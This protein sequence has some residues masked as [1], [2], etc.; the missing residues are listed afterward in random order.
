MIHIRDLTVTYGKIPAL[1]NITFDV[2]PGSWALVSGASGCGKSTL[3]RLLGGLIPHAIPAKISGEISIA[4]F[5]PRQSTIPDLAQHV[6]LVFQNPSTQ[7]FHLR[8]E[9]EVAF[10]PRNL[11]LSVDEVQQ[12]VEWAIQAANLQELRLRR[13]SEL[14]GGQKQ[15]VVIAGALAMQ[16]KVLV[17]DEPTA[18]L[19][20]ANTRRVLE[21]L[22]TLRREQGITILMIEHRLA[23]TLQM[24]DQIILLEKGRLLV[25]GKPSE[26][27]SDPTLLRR[28][29]LRRPQM[30]PFSPGPA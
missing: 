15:C 17:L 20:V 10:G 8:V 9:D 24:A 14:S 1:E 30:N 2:A 26:V 23:G 28:L 13:P 27:L 22:Q 5:D 4:G 25:D 6:G 18:S 29:G 12:R 7:L 19:D 11:G 21:T 3:A 16:P